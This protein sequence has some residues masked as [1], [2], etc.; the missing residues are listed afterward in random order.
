MTQL[1]QMQIQAILAN[2]T[3]HDCM[4]QNKII[5]TDLYRVYLALRPGDAY[6]LSV[7]DL[8]QKFMDDEDIHDDLYFRNAQKAFEDFREE[9][10][11]QYYLYQKFYTD[12]Q[13]ARN[14]IKIERFAEIEYQDTYLLCTLFP[15]YPTL[16]IFAKLN[17]FSEEIVIDAA[18]QCLQGLDKLHQN[19]ICHRNIKPNNIF[20]I[21]ENNQRCFKLGGY[22]FCREIP[23]D[24]DE[25]LSPVLMNT[26]YYAAPESFLGN[27][28]K[29]S[30]I[31]ASGMVLYWLCDDY[32]SSNVLYNLKHSQ[33][34]WL[35]RPKHGSEALWQIIQKALDIR[36][37]NRYQD[38]REML[39]ALQ[40]LKQDA[41]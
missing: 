12:E 27:M 37:Q 19:N 22:E 6:A 36:I 3:F 13:S 15:Y 30:D 14:L 20:C 5:D 26:P 9:I 34:C 38:A 8:K 39:E 23:A 11:N 40:A 21:V 35:P 28:G 10:K 25:I 1:T 18:C 16:H 2:K 4:I 17:P 41:A 32:H 31:Y 24:S 7:M 33:G 29:Y